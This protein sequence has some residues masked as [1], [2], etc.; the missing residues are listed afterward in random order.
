M[1][2]VLHPSF[3]QKSIPLQLHLVSQSKQGFD[4]WERR[5]AVTWSH[6]SDLAFQRGCIKALRFFSPEHLP[7]SFIHW[8][9]WKLSLS[10]S[11]LEALRRLA[12]N[13][14]VFELK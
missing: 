5:C 1:W 8:F 3:P 13:R 12:L 9:H 14:S 7:G 2:K 4:K 11:V 10:S 6:S